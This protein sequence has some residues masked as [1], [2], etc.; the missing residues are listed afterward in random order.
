V[1]N[2][3][4]VLFGQSYTSGVSAELNHTNF[5]SLASIRSPESEAPED[6][7][8]NEDQRAPLIL[9]AVVDKSGSMS[10]AKMASLKQTLT[11]IVKELSRRDQLGI[12]EYD[13]NVY[14]TLPMTSMDASGKERAQS[15]VNALHV[16]SSTNLSGGLQ[17]GLRMIPSQSDGKTVASVLLMTDGLANHGIT[18]SAGIIQL[19]HKVQ[20][21]GQGRCTV[22]T[23]GF[24]SDHDAKMLKEISDAG[25][26]MYYYIENE[27][28]I[29]GSFADCLGGLLSTVGQGLEL[30]IDAAEGCTIQRVLTV[31]TV[32][33]LA[34]GK[35][36]RVVLG[37][38]QEGEERDI[39]FEVSLSACSPT[40]GALVAKLTLTYFDVKSESLKD[41]SADLVVARPA[42]ADLTE[43]QKA[44]N[45]TVDEHFNRVDGGISLDKAVVLAGQ[46]NLEPARAL[47][48]EVINRVNTSPS[49]AQPS[50]IALVSQ[51]QATLDGMRSRS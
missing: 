24:G 14:T 44:I 27:D 22:N 51:L 6:E 12:V 10:G 35:S 21:E 9:V 15:V 42:G 43:E 23:F 50:C 4:L 34:E 5:V 8:L 25:E 3:G 16:G 31:K 18:S 49:R 41:I 30:R 45:I 33:T 32:H 19:M 38:I 37:D 13:T 26:G 40:P 7:T 39:P 48:T 47:L 11:F 36:Y 46:N 2:P 20:S 28:A 1:A 29:A 17:E